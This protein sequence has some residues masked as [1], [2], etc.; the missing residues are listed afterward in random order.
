MPWLDL[1]LSFNQ[2]MDQIEQALIAGKM[3]E[4][5]LKQIINNEISEWEASDELKWM[6]IGY[7]YYRNDTDIKDRV[8]TA[9]GD[10]GAL[11]PV[12]NLANNKL[13]NA[14]T[15][16]LVDQKVGYLLSKPMSVRT[17]DDVY[18]D[19][20]NTYFDKKFLR[21]IQSLGTE[22]INKGIAWLH[23]Y[24]D[25]NGKLRFMITPSEQCIPIWRD[26]AHTEL[27]AMIR[28]YQVQVYEGKD[29]KTYTKVEWWDTTGVRRFV[30]NGND[31]IP[32]V[33]YMQLFGRSLQGFVFNDDDFAKI[34]KGITESRYPHFFANV[35]G[36]NKPFLFRRVPFI[37]FKY[38]DDELPLVKLVKSLVDDYDK[39]KSDN[40][41]NLEDLPNSIYVVKNYGDTKGAEFR[42]NIA[43]YRVVFVDEEGDVKAI[44][45][46]IDTEAFKNHQ[47]T[48]R[49][50][51]YEFGR[52][53]DTQNENF[54]N[55]SG[56]ALKFL[57][58]DLDMDCNII[59][60]QFQAALEQLKWFIDTDLANKG[61]GDFFEKEVEFI[62][63]RDIM[64]NEAEVIQSI[65]DSIG[66]LSD[67][68]LVAQHPWVTDAK[69]ELKRRS[70]QLEKEEKQLG[71]YGNWGNDS[72]GGDINDE[73][74]NEG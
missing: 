59:E 1:N 70:E 43:L 17:D 56:V 37:A 32:D 57:Y 4:M 53:V 2:D 8:R 15:R 58:A 30:Q 11:E 34:Q 67:E 9:V 21:Q 41:N 68:T 62:F 52:G 42:K 36:V 73:Q 45:I 22:S 51:I 7:R 54:G 65:R 46:P 27:Q 12:A 61:L 6:K 55:A 18:Q 19:H 40:A 39:Q 47:A 38:N 66:I 29:R 5:D 3:T 72:A 35:D 16:K 10:S 23:P 49:K 31:L 48:N 20:L 64:I 60:N 26:A 44:S 33:D 69:A 24:Y 71:T 28:Y 63:N 74:G 13:I 50:D 14:F 25:D